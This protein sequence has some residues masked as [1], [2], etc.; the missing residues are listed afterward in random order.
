[1]PCPTKFRMTW[2]PCFSAC[3][4]TAAPMSPRCLPGTHL[5][6]GQLQAFAR[7]V[8]QLLRARRDL[9]DRN[10]DRAVADE[11][12]EDRA[13][14][15]AD[16]VALFEPGAVRDAVNDHVIDR[17]ADDRRI[18][19]QSHR[20]VAFERRLRAA[21]GQLFFGHRVQLRRRRS[22]LDHRPHD[23]EDFE[24]HA[25]GAIHHRDFLAVLENRT[26]HSIEHQDRDFSIRSKTSSTGPTPSTSR[27]RFFAL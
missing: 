2:N 1:M 4:W 14:V 13:E 6:D 26:F 12:V 7:R 27:R 15:E 18:G 23:L 22:G 10:R 9:A 20:S 8:D 25:V 3:S 21:L 24:H 19:R 16:D 5:V 11:A 17:G